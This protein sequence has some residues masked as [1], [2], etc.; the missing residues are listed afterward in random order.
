MNM[1]KTVGGVAIVVAGVLIAGFIMGTLRS[2][3]GLI[4]TAHSGFDS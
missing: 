4:G 2:K 3:V 1:N